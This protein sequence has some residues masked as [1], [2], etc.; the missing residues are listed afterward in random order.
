MDLLL[1]HTIIPDRSPV[2]RFPEVTLTLHS[3]FLT[4]TIVYI[5]LPLSVLILREHLF[6]LTLTKADSFSLYFNSFSRATIVTRFT[7]S[8]RAKFE[9]E[10]VFKV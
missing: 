8:I 7:F 4:L 3:Q 2:G 6:C 10:I 9:E 5:N 1:D